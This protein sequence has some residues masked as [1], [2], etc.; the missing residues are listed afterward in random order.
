MAQAGVTPF[1]APP[2][3]SNQQPVPMRGGVAQAPMQPSQIDEQWIALAKDVVS[4]T[5]EDPYLQN[6]ELAKVKAGYLRARYGKEI[7]VSEDNP[8]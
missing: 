1:S 2:Q 3:S 6:R 8:R 7:K 4:K 5:S